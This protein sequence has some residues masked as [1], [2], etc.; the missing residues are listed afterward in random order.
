LNHP[1]GASAVYNCNPFR[2]LYSIQQLEDFLPIFHNFSFQVNES[3]LFIQGPMDMN[4]C[5]GIFR[6]SVDVYSYIS[7]PAVSWRACMKATSSAFCTEDPHGFGL[8]SVPE[9]KVTI[10]Y[11]GK[12]VPS[13][14]KLLPSMKYSM[15]GLLIG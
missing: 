5:E 12:H 1:S 15:F 11:P 9:S 6:A 10:T 2:A 13:Q 4:G 7:L 8:A 3:L 14:T